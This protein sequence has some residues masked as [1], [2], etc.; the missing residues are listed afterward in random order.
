VR[1]RGIGDDSTGQCGANEIKNQLVKRKE[2]KINEGL[3][4]TREAPV[5]TMG[6]VRLISGKWRPCRRQRMAERPPW[7]PRTPAG[8]R[9]F[10]GSGLQRRCR[11]QAPLTQ[12]RSRATATIPPLHTL[13]GQAE[14][15]IEP[16]SRS[17]TP[18][19]RSQLEIWPSSPFLPVAA[20]MAA[21][22]GNWQQP[23][24]RSIAA[25]GCRTA[26]APATPASPAWARRRPQPGTPVGT[27]RR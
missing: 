27:R 14:L 18:R 7:E 4:P 5:C 19:S 11:C 26:P 6:L 20:A 10:D 12:T 16:A 25:P 22:H 3:I 23:L 9:D 21:A 15:A 1:R 8:A 13:A 17:S 2:K 24:G